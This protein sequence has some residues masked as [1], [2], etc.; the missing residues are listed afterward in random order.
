MGAVV[1]KKE[2]SSEE[3][4]KGIEESKNEEAEKKNEEKE[5]VAEGVQEETQA[6]TE[7][8]ETND[9]RKSGEDSASEESQLLSARGKD[10]AGQTRSPSP[11]VGGGL[12]VKSTT[13]IKRQPV[14][15]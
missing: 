9:M 7:V 10:K 12:R 15:K 11:R 2:N 13:K 14:E 4:E 6:A 1:E 5:T 3:E 8:S